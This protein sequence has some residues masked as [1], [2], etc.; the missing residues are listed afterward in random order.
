L[1][2]VAC[3]AEWMP[4]KVRSILFGWFFEASCEKHDEGYGEGGNEK[5]R[6]VCDLKFLAAMLRDTFRTKSPVMIPK[7]ITAFGYFIAVRLGGWASFNYTKG[8][9]S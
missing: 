7:V 6:L 9:K 8:E 4:E 2:G 1:S 3:G 5:R